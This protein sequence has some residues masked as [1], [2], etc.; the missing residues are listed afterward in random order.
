[1]AQR[2]HEFAEMCW[3]MAKE[4][5]QK[6]DPE[7]WREE[8]RKKQAAG[9]RFE[10][11]SD[12]GNWHKGN[13][14]KFDGNKE[15]YREVPLEQPAIGVI[16]SFN[17]W[18]RALTEKEISDLFSGKVRPEDIPQEVQKEGDMR[19]PEASREV[20]KQWQAKGLKFNVRGVA[21]KFTAEFTDIGK[22]IYTIS[23]QP[24]PESVTI[25][26][27]QAMWEQGLMLEFDG[28]FGWDLAADGFDWNGIY[29]GA[30]LLARLRI[31]AQ[32]IP[33]KLLEVSPPTPHA[34]ERALWKAQREAGTNEVWQ[35]CAQTNVRNW[36]DLDTKYEPN[37]VP[38]CVYRVKPMRLTSVIVRKWSNWDRLQDWEFTGTREEY[39][40]ECEKYGYVVISEIKEVV[41]KPKMV[42]YY[43]AMVKYPNGCVNS[44]V[45]YD[46]EQ[47]ITDAK[48][49]ACTIIGDI[50][51]REIE[52]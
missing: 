46:K 7:A 1:M 13:S 43:M 24:I 21:V 41:E 14:W 50:E 38:G 18:D 40:A 51:E 2:A 48:H 11:I 4:A 20:L 32:P 9:V 23:E 12:G 37:W 29:R 39:R 6:T 45:A 16:S 34:A 30:Q 8:N 15:Y 27:A 10:V 49:C 28:N 19:I 31:P 5:E 22:N 33:E 25:E 35:C 42:K 36:V 3:R 44:W 47:I 17:K 52:A 26:Q